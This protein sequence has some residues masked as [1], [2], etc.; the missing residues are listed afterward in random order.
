MLKDSKSDV[1][2]VDAKK[3]KKNQKAEED[4]KDYIKSV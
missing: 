2:M 1:E 3:K 4:K